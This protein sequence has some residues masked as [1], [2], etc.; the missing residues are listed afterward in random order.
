MWHIWRNKM[1]ILQCVVKKI[2]L[3]V[4]IAQICNK[5]FEVSKFPVLFIYSLVPHFNIG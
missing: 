2:A 3:S 1:E 4:L 5:A